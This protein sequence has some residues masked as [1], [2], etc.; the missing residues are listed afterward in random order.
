MS[1][2]LIINRIFAI[3]AEEASAWLKP[4][5]SS[6]FISFIDLAPTLLEAAG[7]EPLSEMTGKSLINILTSSHSG[8]VDPLRNQILA[9][10]E[11]HAYS[12]PGNIGYPCR[13]IHTD[14]YL[15]IHNYKPER[16]PA[17]N[18]DTYSDIDNSPTKKY[19]ITHCNDEK[20][21]EFFLAFGKRPREELY[22]M[23][24][25]YACLNNMAYDPSY[26]KIKEEIKN[27]L[28]NTLREQD[29]PR[30]FGKGDVSDTY[31]YYL[32]P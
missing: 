5:S 2:P 10:L 8:R 21:G 24:D 6:D 13:C 1:K 9:G 16:W 7:L 23:K 14:D 3:G 30:M 29:D 27:L 19:M 17:G 26:G 22:S 15:Y 12:R 20:V 32:K 11:R 4:C 31:K 18:P 28:E 25:G